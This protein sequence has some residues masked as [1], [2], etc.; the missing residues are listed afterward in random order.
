LWALEGGERVL[1]MVRAVINSGLHEEY[2]ATAGQTKFILNSPYGIYQ[3]ILQVYRNGVLQR[4]GRDYRETDHITIEFNYPL[5]KD[6]LITFHQAGATDPIAGTILESEIGRMKI[7]YGYT[8]MMLHDAIQSTA[9]DYLDMYIDTFITDHSIDAVNSFQYLYQDKSISVNDL[10]SII[11]TKQDFENGVLTDVDIQTFP[12]EIVLQ[13]LSGGA[14][15]HG[16]NPFV[17]VTKDRNLNEV[18]SFYNNHHQE[19]YFYSEELPTGQCI[20]KV[21]IN[22]ATIDLN[23]T[24]GY[25]FGLSAAQDSRGNIHLAYH[26]Q[27]SSVGKSKIHY[28][29]FDAAA[30]QISYSTIISDLTQ[31]AIRPDIFVDKDDVA[32]IA[33]SSKR[34]QPAYFNIDYRTVDHGVLSGFKDITTLT[35]SDCLNPRIVVGSDKKARMVFESINF[36]GATRNIRYTVMHDGVREFSLWVTQSTTYDNAMPDIAIDDLDSVSLVWKSKRLSSTYGIDFCQIPVTNI[37]SMVHSIATG[38]FICDYPKV[39]VDYEGISHIVFNAN[40]VRDDTQNLVYSY[41]YPDGSIS[42]LEDIAALY[43]TQFSDPRP[44]VYGDRLVVSFLGDTNGFKID[45][46]LTNYTGIGRFDYVYDSKAKQSVWNGV[47]DTAM[48]DSTGAITIDCRASD[49]QIIWTDWVS[50][51]SLVASPLKGR[52][53]HTRT[54][55]TSI[56]PNITPIVT[57]ITALYRPSFIE[58]QSLPKLSSKE[59]DAAILIAKY[60]GDVTFAVSR[61]AGTSFADATLETAVNLLMQNPGKEMVIKAKIQDGSRLDAWGILW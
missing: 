10:Q 30:L 59:V 35:T 41:V 50:A 9:T 54:T 16:F 21:D 4:K 2:N 27:G 32:H 28:L 23:S 55:L 43:G 7:N 18:L 29:I 53:L 58:I 26:E 19:F 36:D 40:T 14:E 60:E 48:N 39:G 11:T 31:D 22:G 3:N 51:S 57:D 5:I 44:C 46:P 1:F 33:F 25:F 38:S 52:Y 49:D 45:K 17:Q 61:D 47:V 37:P 34:V 24:D 15:A 20:L 42:N 12:D 13:N 8:T 6:D 56:D